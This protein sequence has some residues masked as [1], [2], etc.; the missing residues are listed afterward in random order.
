MAVRRT[1]PEPAM[2]AIENAIKRSE[3]SHQGEIRLAVEA[4][5]GTPALLKG[6]TGRE[7]AVEVFSHLRVWDTEQNNGVLIYLL[8]ADHHVE[9]VADRGVNARVKND[10]WES[11]CRKMES[12]F[13]R[14]QFESGVIA[15]IEAIGE[16]L[17]EHF[18]TRNEGGEN[19]LPNRPV[20]LGE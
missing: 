8:L 14:G 18:P 7:R 20:I 12:S 2:L 10:E 15:G 19:E 1:F 13:A 17:Q 16:H 4:A 5:L 9:I 11:I 3:I 6:Q